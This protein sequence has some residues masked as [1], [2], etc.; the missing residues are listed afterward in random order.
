MN[1]NKALIGLLSCASVLFPL[2]GCGSEPPAAPPES[3]ES[4]SNAGPAETS[5]QELQVGGK[6]VNGNSS[7]QQ[8]AHPEGYE[9]PSDVAKRL[10]LV[11][12]IH[13]DMGW[14]PKAGSA[15]QRSQSSGAKP[16]F[17]GPY[18]EQG[19]A[20]IQ[21]T[22]TANCWYT[23][24]S[25][26][27]EYLS[28]EPCDAN[29]PNQLFQENPNGVNYQYDIVTWRGNCL[30]VVGGDPMTGQYGT[31]EGLSCGSSPTEWHNI[32]NQQTQVYGGV[33]KQPCI[34]CIITCN[35]SPC[36][37]QGY[38]QYGDQDFYNS[39]FHGA[40]NGKVNNCPISNTLTP[41]SPASR[42][43]SSTGYVLDL[44]GNVRL[45]GRQV[46]VTTY[47]GS[48]AQFWVYNDPNTWVVLDN[49]NF[50][51]TV[52]QGAVPG[53]TVQS[54]QCGWSTLFTS[55]QQWEVL[56]YYTENFATGVYLVNLYSGWCLN[57]PSFQTSSTQWAT[58]EP[59]NAGTN[60]AW[61]WPP[62]LTY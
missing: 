45:N 26:G 19:W 25:S 2:L 54:W 60:Q 52:P 40:C 57:V 23:Y 33:A 17:S 48:S 11:E 53:T 31:I 8:P 12:L 39:F 20:W 18:A 14:K 13:T 4:V 35:T 24:V 15:N 29:N 9:D 43:G 38:G 16:L 34:D 56:G 42:G 32:D 21:D 61:N 49:S 46:D 10:G 51:L 44:N 58:V 6:F 30:G 22:S 50:C 37:L 41:F 3:H 1:A 7:Q 47:N 55:Q 36:T 27:I 5:E 62:S 59:C 28:E